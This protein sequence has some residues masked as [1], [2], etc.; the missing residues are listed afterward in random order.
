LQTTKASRQILCVQR[1]LFITFEGSEGC[2]K[3]TQ[4][5]LLAERL[6]QRGLAVNLTREPGGTPVGEEIRHLLQFSSANTA[7]TPEAELLLFT[8]SRAQLVREIILPA[9]ESGVSVISDR[10]MDSTT[11]YQGVARAIDPERVKAINE[12]A[13][14]PCRPDLTFVLDLDCAQARKRMALRTP[15][16][17]APDRMES[18]PIA[19]YEAVRQGYLALAATEPTRFRVVDA[20][21]DVGQVQE[22]I[23]NL[24]EA[25]LPV[26]QPI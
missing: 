20:S 19:F 22:I 4:I 24:V 17:G 3:S 15:V 26:P 2:G 14:G 23:W 11:V 10:F 16:G 25:H 1:G 18:E 13:V 9:L 6:R 8:A 5:R 7:M 21:G 12:F